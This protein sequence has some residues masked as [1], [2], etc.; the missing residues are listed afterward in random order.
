LS[1]NITILGSSAALPTNGR[2][3]SSQF[4][5]IQG[6][7]FLVD[8]G[9]GSQM[10]LRR[11]ELNLYRINHIF[12]S[13]LHGDHYLGLMGLLFT[14]HLQQRTNEL[15]LYGHSGLDEIITIQ[16]RHSRSSLNYL[17]IFHTIEKE[18]HTIIF[19][20]EKVQ[21]ET[22]PLIH[23]IPS[24]GFLFREKPKLRKVDKNK[25]PEGLLIQQ[26]AA[27]KHGDDI[28]NE[29]GEM[30]FKNSDLTMDARPSRSYAY[31]SD[32]AYNPLIIPII[33]NIDLLYHE[34][35]FLEE[36]KQKAIE[37]MHSTAREAAHIAKQAHV[38]KLMLGH[39]SARY[40]EIIKLKE[41]AQNTFPNTDLAIEGETF[42]IEE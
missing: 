42:S 14:M 7:F 17:L 20:D 21:V 16:L 31:C 4:I 6:R 19:E 11:Y 12:I 33:E 25:L 3:P 32:T 22:I 23:K 37:T 35:T 2:F 18:K 8:C 29:K 27:L 34:A 40:K 5:E 26:I 30:L 13:H 36:D 24:T 41:E 10:Q 38:K 28:K 15:H 9:E 1:F 39:F